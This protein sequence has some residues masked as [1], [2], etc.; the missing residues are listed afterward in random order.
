MQ[1]MVDEVLT[2]V[3]AYLN[4]QSEIKTYEI[5][6]LL[7]SVVSLLCRRGY[8]TEALLFVEGIA[9]DESL[10]K[11]SR[12]KRAILRPAT[13]SMLINACAMRDDGKAISLFHALRYREGPLARI[14]CDEGFNEA[15]NRA[16]HS[17]AR[18]DAVSTN[19]KMQ[20][21]SSKE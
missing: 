7:A 8:V 5:R 15:V 10:E 21:T 18:S 14:I 13:L 6:S 12:H 1:G 9:E 2:V 20:I 3:S 11:L 17:L 19:L 16:Y 4:D